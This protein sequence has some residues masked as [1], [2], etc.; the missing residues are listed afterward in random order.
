[1][2]DEGDGLG[3]LPVTHARSRPGQAPDGQR[4]GPG[5]GDAGGASMNGTS[6]EDSGGPRGA[7]ATTGQAGPA[8]QMGPA[9]PGNPDGPGASQASGPAGSGGPDANAPGGPGK[10]PGRSPAKVPPKKKG[11]SFWKELPILIVVALILTLVIKTY[12]IQAFFIPSGSMQNTLGIGDRV[13]VNKVVYDVRSIHRG[14][15]VVFSG[16]GSWNPGTPPASTNFIAKFGESVASMFGFARD[17]NDYIKRVIGVPGDHVACCDAEGRVTVNGVPLNEKSYLFPG[18]SPS[19]NRFSVTVPANSL[20]VMGDHRD[21]SWDSRGHRY[22][23]P[24]GGSIP[25]SA[26]VGRAF[27]IIWPVSQWAVLPIPS[28]FQQPVLTGSTAA[29]SAAQP[30]GTRSAQAAAAVADTG[31]PVHPSSPAAPLALGFAGAI[32]LT[33]LQR[34]LRT[35]SRRR[36]RR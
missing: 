25:E 16:D 13:L 10:G 27:I 34:R 12:A 17:Q 11:R 3:E 6:P 28:T 19:E 9:S 36:S 5:T 24:G 33:L 18:S 35:L 15:I 22:G 26:V 30:S 21:V 14:D 7:S 32:P 29:Q 8:S 31:S 1:M 2:N 23:F 4:S 20:W